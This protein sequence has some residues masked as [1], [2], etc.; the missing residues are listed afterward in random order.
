V[1][2]PGRPS[3]LI[4]RCATSAATAAVNA[5]ASPA[6]SQPS[7]TAPVGHSARACAHENCRGRSCARTL[8]CASLLA[9]KPVTPGMR[10]TAHTTGIISRTTAPVGATL[11]AATTTSALL[12]RHAASNSPLGRLA[13]ATASPSGVVSCVGSPKTGAGTRRP[14]RTSQPPDGMPSTMLWARAEP[15][16]PGSVARDA[17]ASTRTR[18][19][20]G[21]PAHR[22]RSVL[23]VASTP[24][25]A[26]V[27]NTRPV[28]AAA[29]SRSRTSWTARSSLATST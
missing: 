23:S 19:A 22:R 21:W 14:C 10:K 27:T 3:P 9:A 25:P 15:I 24:K 16:T 4:S 17:T 13:E 28:S 5:W 18:D 7:R 20:G 29:R 2:A 12:A 11:E 8:T 6:R 26:P 1:Y